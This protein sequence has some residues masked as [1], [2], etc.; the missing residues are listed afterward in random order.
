MGM[1][2]HMHLVKDGEYVKK[3]IYDGRNR[4]WFANLQD[5][6]WDDCYDNLDII[7]GLS[8]KAPKTIDVAKLREDGYFGFYHI[9]VKRFKEWFETYRPDKDAGWVSTYDKWRI[10]NKGYVPDDLM[11]YIPEDARIEDLHFVEVVNPYDCS[12]WLYQYL[13]ENEIDNNADITYWFDA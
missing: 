6:G 4:E 5:E 3:N 7:F 8:P 13:I 1:D 9:P 11:H 10:E 2:I 12:A